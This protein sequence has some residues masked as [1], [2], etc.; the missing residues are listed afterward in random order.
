MS[1]ARRTLLTGGLAIMGSGYPLAQAS[2]IPC[3]GFLTPATS[4]RTIP[5]SA[6]RTALAELGY[7]EGQNIALEF[8]LAAGDISRL[9]ALAAELVAL[10]ADVIV[11]D[12]GIAVPAVMAATKTIPVVMATAGDPVALGYV[13]SLSRPGGNITGFSL[14]SG[15]LN[16]KRL[17]LLRAAFPNAENVAV[18]FNPQ[19]PTAR[20]GLALVKEAGERLGIRVALVELSSPEAILG[21]RSEALASGRPSPGG[22]RCDVLEQPTSDH[23]PIGR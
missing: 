15:E 14:I 23:H 6:F 17:D 1:I 22:A 21:L 2:W 7:V 9:P 13:Q 19:N 5:I 16:Q 11:V 4:D 8:R 3:V 12:G 20:A 10:P 18:V